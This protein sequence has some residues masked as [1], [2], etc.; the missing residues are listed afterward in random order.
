MSSY[1]GQR[2]VIRIHVLKA[3]H[4]A[5]LKNIHHFDTDDDSVPGLNKGEQTNHD[6]GSIS[7]G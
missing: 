4:L 2:D 6:E 5:F 7:T 1:L 3:F